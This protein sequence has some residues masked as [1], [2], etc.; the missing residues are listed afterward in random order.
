VALKKKKKNPTKKSAGSDPADQP[1]FGDRVFTEAV[2]FK[3]DTMFARELAY[4]TSDGDV[5]RI[6]EC[7][8]VCHNSHLN[9]II[10]LNT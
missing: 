6:W 3:R 10:V 7:I 8:K 5:G 4:S 9:Y 2:T 1:F